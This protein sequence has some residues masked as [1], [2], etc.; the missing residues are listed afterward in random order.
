MAIDEQDHPIEIKGKHANYTNKLALITNPAKTNICNIPSIGTLSLSG[1]YIKRDQ[2]KTAC[3]NCKKACKKCDI[4]RPC[5]RCKNYGITETCRDSER[6][7]RQK[8]VV[9][10]PYS[11][12]RSQTRESSPSSPHDNN[13][14]SLSPTVIIT[15]QL[16]P[17]YITSLTNPSKDSNFGEEGFKKRKLNTSKEEEDGESDESVVATIYNDVRLIQNRKENHQ[18]QYITLSQYS[19]AIF[20]D[21][22]NSTINNNEMESNHIIDHQ[23]P[24]YPLISSSLI[25]VATSLRNISPIFSSTLSSRGR[26]LPGLPIST[27]TKSL[28]GD[29]RNAK[30]KTLRENI[31]MKLNQQNQIEKEKDERHDDDTDN[32]ETDEDD[33][34]RSNASTVEN[35][36]GTGF[37][38]EFGRHESVEHPP[39]HLPPLT[40]PIIS[41]QQQQERLH[42][43]SN[44]SPLD[45]LAF[46]ADTVTQYE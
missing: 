29:V 4:E 9:R 28:Y 23:Y 32:D 21:N 26:T 35:L 20:N 16:P 36:E 19:N 22:R 40:H 43:F 44:I 39:P 13:N 24:P 27:T 7:T 42:N 11:K 8:G 41:Q 30:S 3:S 5:Q 38:M 18:P 33:D 1:E 10:G 37:D 31:V 14:S 25:Q 45:I 15:E 46:V 12:F 2:V 34:I 6:K 17:L